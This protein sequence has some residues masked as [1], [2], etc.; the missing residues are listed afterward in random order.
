M[1]Y[2]VYHWDYGDQLCHEAEQLQQNWQVQAT[3]AGWSSP[4]DV[5]A[6]AEKAARETLKDVVAEFD[7]AHSRAVEEAL[8][9]IELTTFTRQRYQTIIEKLRGKSGRLPASLRSGKGK[10]G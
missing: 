9:S 10:E 6:A 5:R 3:E 1:S 2:D 8:T 4:E 7:Y